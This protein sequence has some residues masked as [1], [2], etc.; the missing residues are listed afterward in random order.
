MVQTYHML[1]IGMRHVVDSAL[2]NRSFSEIMRVTTLSMCEVADQFNTLFDQYSN[3]VG[4]PNFE[5]I[6]NSSAVALPSHDVLVQPAQVLSSDAQS[7][8]VL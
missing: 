2:Q 4:A 6:T 5:G 8:E 7:W 3:R 1:K